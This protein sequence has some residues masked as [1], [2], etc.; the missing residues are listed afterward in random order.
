MDDLEPRLRRNVRIDGGTGQASVIDV[1][2]AVTELQSSAASHLVKGFVEKYPHVGEKFKHG[3][4]DGKGKATWLA[5]FSVV[6]D[7][8]FLVNN[9]L[10]VAT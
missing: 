10:P 7:V 5:N 8:I 3:Q 9:S 1:V 2:W 4:I 6:T